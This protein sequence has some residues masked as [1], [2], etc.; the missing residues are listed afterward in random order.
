MISL[1]VLVVFELVIFII[2]ILIHPALMIL[3]PLG[4]I[5]LWWLIK[6]PAIALMIM[7]LT[8]II[9]G[10]LITYVPIFEIIDITLVTTII[11]WLG[12]IKMALEGKWEIPDEIKTPVFLFLVFGLLLIVSLFYSPSP[13]YGLRKIIRFNTFAF[14]MFITPIIVI[15]SSAD[16]KR[17]L[18]MFKSLLV[19]I[20]GIM[21]FQFVYFLTKGDFAVVLAF[22]NRISIPGANPIQVSRYLAI[23]AG[24]MITILIRNRQ[25]QSLHHLVMLSAILLS[26]ILSGSRG[27]LVSVVF[28]ILVYALLFEKDHIKR[29]V[30]F[31]FLAITLVT[32]LLL[33]LPED[34]TERF[35]NIA[36]G[37]VVLTQQGIRR[38]STIMTRFEFWSMSIQTWFS[39]IYN[40]VFG[41]GAGGFSSLFIWRDWHWYPHNLFF[42][43]MAELGC[44]GLLIGSAFIKKSFEKIKAGL[45]LGSFT[46][47]TALWVSGTIVMFFA[48]QFSGDFNDNR[49][50]WMLIGITIAST[51]VDSL[52][53]LRIVQ[54]N[55]VKMVNVI[56]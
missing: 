29:I 40:F 49:V 33:L 24:M 1:S 18:T 14:T 39:S 51:H 44:I 12:L 34:L 16:S 46:D 4:S 7:S 28:G 31:G 9:K 3:I 41:L 15:K 22:W 50:L 56:D 6:N 10:Y 54:N 19:V 38:V 53:R 26:I 42:E 48:A 43:T 11:I 37:S 52:E 35:L 45:H 55:S 25:G 23:G 21:L 17:L 20:I 32:I 5:M 13:V 30:G 36:Q 47:H 8:A 2:G 27:P